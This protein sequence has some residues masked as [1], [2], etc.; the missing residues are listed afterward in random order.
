VIRDTVLAVSGALNLKAGGPSFFPAL[1]KEVHATQDTAGKG[2]TDSPP[3]EQNRRSIYIFVKRALLPPLLE[4]FDYTT[5]TVPV[6]ARA[7]TTVAPQALMLL[8]DEFMQAQA[9]A[10]AG[11]LR[12]EAG[13]GP[14]AQVDRAFALALQRQPT[15]KEKRAALAMLREQRRLAEGTGAGNSADA[16]LRGFCLAMLNLNELIYID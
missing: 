7:V 10:L 4:A 6:G 2:W 8:N 15:S 16:A 11:R 13:S 14:E 9:A 12:R 5:T 1:P 3:E